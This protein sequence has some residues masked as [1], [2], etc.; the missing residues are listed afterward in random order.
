MSRTPKEDKD[1]AVHVTVSVPKW[2]QDRMK[3]YK[4]T[5]NWSSI[6]KNAFEIEIAKLD[7]AAP[8]QE[9]PVE[10]AVVSAPAVEPAVEPTP[11]AEVTPEAA[12]PVADA[13]VEV[14]SD[15]VVVEAPPAEAVQ[16]VEPTPVEVK[17]EE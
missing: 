16:P 17:K 5:I 4:K 13:G 12:L 7:A 1:R 6:A 8:L 3:A 2:L 10:P 11:A 9:A 15:G 14:T